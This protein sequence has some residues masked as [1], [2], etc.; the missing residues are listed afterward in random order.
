MITVIVTTYLCG[1]LIIQLWIDMKIP[2]NL[3]DSSKGVTS[4][5]FSELKVTL[6]MTPQEGDK[7][8]VAEL[9]IEKMTR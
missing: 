1:M 4:V 7:K 9:M 2:F 5:T 6:M 3:T 8:R